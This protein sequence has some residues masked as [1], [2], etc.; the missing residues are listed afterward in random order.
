MKINWDRIILVPFDEGATFPTVAECQNCE[1]AGG[2]DTRPR[3]GGD[4][5]EPDD[6]YWDGCDNCDEQGY[7][8]DPTA[9]AI[10]RYT[11]KL[12]WRKHEAHPTRTLASLT[13][14]IS[15]DKTSV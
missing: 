10:R 14:Q 3:S 9:K 12:S 13:G 6:Y 7:F 1:G 8:F 4:R 2:F 15:D 11:I 5:M